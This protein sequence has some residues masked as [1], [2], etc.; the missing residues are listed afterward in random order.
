MGFIERLPLNESAGKPNTGHCKRLQNMQMKQKAERIIK[1][2]L[3]NGFKAYIAG[4][5][6]RDM[7]AGEIPADFDIVTNAG[8]NEI[9]KIFKYENVK[10]AGKAFTVCVVG[11]IEIASC[12]TC[13][14]TNKADAVFPDADLA[15][16]DFTINSMAFD[17]LSKRIIDPFSGRNDLENKIIRFTG[18]PE[19]RIME[20]P[21]RMIRAC[22]FA[23]KIKGELA[24]SSLAA[25]KK[26]KQLICRG[27]AFERIRLEILK[28]MEYS[29]PSIFF[30][31]LYAAGLLKY[32]L[33]CLDRCFDLDG[34]PHHG[35]TVF[36]HCMLAGDALSPKKPL[37]RLAGYLHDVGKYDAAELKEGK[38]TFPGHEKKRERVISDLKKLKLSIRE[39][40][41]IDSLICVHMRPLAENTT[42]K[43]VRR[44]LALLEEKGISHR[45][46][47]RMRIADKRGNLAK[48]PYTFREIRTR[49]EKL[50]AE[51]HGSGSPAFTIKNL[52]ITG[53]DIMTILGIPPGPRV[54]KILE[55]LFEKVMDNP[56]LNNS[57]TLKQ[58][59]ITL[60]PMALL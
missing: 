5:A 54:G 25:I 32:I 58:I 52:A 50:K 41:Y 2:L 34:G 44:I 23:A 30:Y 11:K 31:T 56:C 45:D 17:P 35:E 13:N 24:P 28:I 36:H 16:R 4:G 43:A 20:D 47:L 29:K 3:Q 22:R 59:V 10:K 53:N 49:L 7:I 1:T 42:P 40:D 46:F 60:D 21:V 33:P 9:Q 19:D 48:S 27:L 38:L 8:L 6:V 26:H 55:Y 37:L 15:K 18:D 57:K 39:I 14:N 12:R 51:L